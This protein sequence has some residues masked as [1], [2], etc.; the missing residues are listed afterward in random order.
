MIIE[1]R[2]SGESE[3]TSL[4]SGSAGA[5]AAPPINVSIAARSR[6]SSVHF[7]GTNVFSVHFVGTNVFFISIHSCHTP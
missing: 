6:N 2:Y 1:T 5:T 4:I 7:V 3:N